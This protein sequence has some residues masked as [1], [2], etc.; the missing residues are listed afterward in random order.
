VDVF[1]F[2]KRRL[3]LRRRAEAE[4]EQLIAAHGDAAWSVVYGRCRDHALPEE[5]R[6]FAYKVRRIIEKRLGT[7]PRVDT[8]TRYLED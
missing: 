1:G 5:E 8:A 3:E 4:A 6:A 2:V 7:P